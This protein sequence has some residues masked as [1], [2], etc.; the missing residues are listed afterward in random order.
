VEQTVLYH[1]IIIIIIISSLNILLSLI[2][3]RV[4]SNIKIIISASL[5]RK[6]QLILSTACAP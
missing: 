3:H 5:L 4:N 6:V 2:V 1:I